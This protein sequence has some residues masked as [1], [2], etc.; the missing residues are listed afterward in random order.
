MFKNIFTESGQTINQMPEDTN[1]FTAFYHSQ[2][3]IPI[4]KGQSKPSSP[5]SF[6]LSKDSKQRRSV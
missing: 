3:Q 6:Y 5:Q 1:N 4:K 2:T